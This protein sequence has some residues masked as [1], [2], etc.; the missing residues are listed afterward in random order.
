MDLRPGPDQAYRKSR[1]SLDYLLWTGLGPPRKNAFHHSVWKRLAHCGTEQVLLSTLFNTIKKCLQ[2]WRVD[3]GLLS[4]IMLFSCY[5]WNWLGFSIRLLRFQASHRICREYADLIRQS[6][7]KLLGISQSST[8]STDDMV[9]SQ[10]EQ[11]I[12]DYLRSNADKYNIEQM[13]KV[14]I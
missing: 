3:R 2:R 8:R 9:Q 10:M 1:P 7:F 12:N 4:A 14:G 5:T 6:I 13:V 11:N